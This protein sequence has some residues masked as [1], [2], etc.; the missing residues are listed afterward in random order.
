[1]SSMPGCWAGAPVSPG[2]HIQCILILPVPCFMG[3][4]IELEGTLGTIQFHPLPRAGTPLSS[5]SCSSCD[6]VIL[7]GN[8]LF[9]SF[10]CH[11][12]PHSPNHYQTLDFGKGKLTF[13][14]L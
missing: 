12:F 14:H 7:C 6:S 13:C 8:G 1:M 5:P 3:S 2:F 10:P 4:H 9:N 11:S